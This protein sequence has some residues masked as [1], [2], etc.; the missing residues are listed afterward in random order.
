MNNSLFTL[1]V[2]LLIGSF[3]YSQR[4]V[5]LISYKPWKSFDGYNLLYAHRQPDVILL[6]NCGEIVHSWEGE[7]GRVPGNVAYIQENGNLVKTHR[8]S[9]IS[10]D[11]IWAGGGGEAVEIV[12]WENESLWYYEINNEEERMHHDISVLPDGNILIV[13]WE[14]VTAEEAIAMGRV[15]TLLADGEL[16]PDK[17]IEVNPENDEIVWECK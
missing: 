5:G 15:D 13:V 8:S 9:D 10:G 2:C 6:D 17:I 11:A 4:T 16:W 12:S 1:L 14:K 3:T 7:E